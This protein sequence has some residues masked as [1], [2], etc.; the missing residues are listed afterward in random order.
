MNPT[1]NAAKGQQ[2]QN[3][4][5]NWPEIQ[6]NYRTKMMVVYKHKHNVLVPMCVMVGH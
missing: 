1:R 6:R 4:A 3:E 5:E 2:P